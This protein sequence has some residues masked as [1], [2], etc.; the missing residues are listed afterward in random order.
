MDRFI[1]PRLVQRRWV[2][3]ERDTVADLAKAGRW[4]ALFSVITKKPHL[5]NAWR[6]GGKSWYAPLHQAAHWGAPADVVSRLL[7][8]GAWRT[9]RTAR[10]ERS[11]DIAARRKHEALVEVLTPRPVLPVS[12]EA[13]ASIQAAFHD[14]ILGR[15]RHLDGVRLLQLP[16][17]GPLTEVDRGE[18]WFPVPGMMGGFRFHL[19]PGPR[20]ALIS[21]SWC[22]AVDGSGERHEVTEDGA[23]LV[24][25]GFV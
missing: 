23:H 16:E 11:C 5:I 12:P 25:R 17:L 13:L 15:T 7:D 22:R 9:L 20:P 18:M 10:G 19:R 3:E 8:L 6:I 2:S 4:A 21:E 1:E 24:D 14:V